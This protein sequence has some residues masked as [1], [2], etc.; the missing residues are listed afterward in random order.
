MDTTF[1]PAHYSE[2]VA[3]KQNK[4]VS[5]HSVEINAFRYFHLPVPLLIQTPNEV[6]I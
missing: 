5:F 3:R 6:S 4:K 1:T 2:N